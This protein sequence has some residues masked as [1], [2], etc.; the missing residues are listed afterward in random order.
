ML[1][2]TPME[3]SAGVYL[4]SAILCDVVKKER[5]SQ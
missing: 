2:S 4:E 3:D 1:L 5:C